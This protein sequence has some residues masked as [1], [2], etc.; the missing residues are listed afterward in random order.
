MGRPGQRRTRTYD[1]HGRLATLTDPENGEESYAY[2]VYGNQ[3]SR[4][5]PTGEQFTYAYTPLGQ[6]AEVTLK[7]YDD[8]G[9]TPA[10]VVLDSYAYDPTGRLAEHTDAMGRTTR[11][12][13]YD[14]GLLAQTILA[15]FQDS[16][17]TTRDLV[18]SERQHD[19]AG[20]LVTE[21]TGNGTVTTTYDVDAAGRTTAETLDP[22][23]LAR[24]TA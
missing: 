4:T 20:H 11:Q 23:G 8:G 14:D 2:D 15:G 21:I 10:D 17:G 22:A 19:A 16:D 7:G 1:V 12:T 9:G 6:L 24:R 13:Y 18:L 5:M 3:T